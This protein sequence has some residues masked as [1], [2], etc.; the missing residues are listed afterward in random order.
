[1]LLCGYPPFR[2]EDTKVLIRETTNAKVEFHE[3]YWK[4]ISSEGEIFPP[5]VPFTYNIS[6]AKTFIKSLLNPDPS[7]R[8]SAAQA[9]ADPWL[10]THEPSEEHDLSHGLREHFDPKARW[11]AAIASARAL[12]R[13]QSFGRR[14]SN[15]STSSGGWM[16]DDSSDDELAAAK[17]PANLEPDPGSNEFVKITGPEELI[18]ETEGKLSVDSLLAPAI[19]STLELEDEEEKHTG[20]QTPKPREEEMFTDR[21]TFYDEPESSG[22][23]G[24]NDDVLPMPGSFDLIGPQIARPQGDEENSWADMLKRLRL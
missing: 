14:A 20:A 13:L 22:E 1:M 17:S 18:E 11:R 4:N 8:P 5:K 16:N 7:Q 23:T 10:T 2:S 9:L 24:Q 19:S 12:N 6:L 3:R 21:T 15:K